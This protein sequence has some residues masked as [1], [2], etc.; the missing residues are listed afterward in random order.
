MISLDHLTNLHRA[1][2]A[3]HRDVAQQTHVPEHV[4]AGIVEIELRVGALVQ[5][6]LTISGHR[7]ATELETVAWLGHL[8]LEH[9]GDEIPE[10]A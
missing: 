5:S 2:S 3:L 7:K 4:K 9:W 10:A 8:V 6:Y 1:L